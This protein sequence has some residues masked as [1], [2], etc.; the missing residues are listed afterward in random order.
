MNNITTQTKLDNNKLI[1]VNEHSDLS[2][3]SKRRKRPSYKKRCSSKQRLQNRLAKQEKGL[4]R[5][6]GRP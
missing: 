3:S 2:K 1:I 4:H 5:D 6:L